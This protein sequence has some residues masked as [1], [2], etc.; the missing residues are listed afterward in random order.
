MPACV[1]AVYAVSCVGGL[2]LGQVEPASAE[3]QPVYT[4]PAERSPQFE[5]DPRTKKKPFGQWR[6]GG[7][8]GLGGGTEFFY[9][10]VSPA[11][12]YL[13]WDR[14]EPGLG[15]IYQYSA[16]HGPQPTVKRHTVGGR[17]LLRAYIVEGL[18]V[19]TEGQLVNTGL[20]QGSFKPPRDNFFTAFAGG[21]YAIPLGSGAYAFM[22]FKVNLNTNALYPDRR[23]F[24]SAGIGVGL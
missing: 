19:M 6:V 24:I 17:L 5:T 22:T 14:L 23:P 21:G 1:V 13:M 3:S 4:Q 9:V 2:A 16:D 18:F 8:L 10:D 12:H 7:S 15:F 11:V 20:K